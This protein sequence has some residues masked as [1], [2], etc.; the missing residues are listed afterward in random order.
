MLK[1]LGNNWDNDL[2]SCFPMVSTRKENS[3][4]NFSY[5]EKFLGNI[6]Y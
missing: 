4:I 3:N 6:K 1:S 2:V 5:V